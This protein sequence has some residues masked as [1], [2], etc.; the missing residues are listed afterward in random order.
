MSEREK[1]EMEGMA[2]NGINER[3]SEKRENVSEREMGRE[4]GGR[5]TQRGERGRER[6]EKE[7]WRDRCPTAVVDEDRYAPY[8][9]S[10]VT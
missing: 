2:L 5:G 7:R 10:T 4:T 8:R 3:K 6:C 9:N 1:E